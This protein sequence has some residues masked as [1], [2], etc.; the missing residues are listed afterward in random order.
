[1]EITIFSI[2][3]Y[4]EV[5]IYSRKIIKVVKNKLEKLK[6]GVNSFNYTIKK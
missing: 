5:K 6:V 2:M 1:M 4:T 3:F